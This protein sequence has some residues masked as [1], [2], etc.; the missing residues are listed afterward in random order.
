LPGTQLQLPWPFGN[1]DGDA[2]V[3]RTSRSADFGSGQ[4]GK[5]LAWHMAQSGGRTTVIERSESEAQAR[6]MTERVARLPM[7]AVLRSEA[8]D[9]KQVS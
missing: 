3:V 4:G 8:T 9:E 5:L 2:Y 6:G 1:G 7:S